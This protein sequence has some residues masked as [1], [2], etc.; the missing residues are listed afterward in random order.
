[1]QAGPGQGVAPLAGLTQVT[2]ALRAVGLHAEPDAAHPGD[3]GHVVG[4][5]LET[6]QRVLHRP[7]GAGQVAAAQQQVGAQG[8]VEADPLR[9]VGHGDEILRCVQAVGRPVLVADAQRHLGAH[10]LAVDEEQARR[11]RRGR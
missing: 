11:P 6:I 7:L 3:P 4:A 5:D 2:R 1:M 10:Q 8:P 9:L